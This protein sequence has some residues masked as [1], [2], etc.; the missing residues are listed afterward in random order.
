M[1]TTNADGR[2]RKSLAEQIDRLDAILDG[3]S[4]ALEG[5]VATAVSQAVGVAVKEAVQGVLAEV[6]TNPA[7]QEKLRGMA[8]PPPPAADPQPVAT[9]GSRLK[10]RLA[11]LGRRARSLGG[12]AG[13]CLAVLW[14]RVRAARP[15]GVAA[16]ALG[17]GVLAGVVAHFAG[18]SL[19]PAAA[20]ITGL[21]GRLAT[22]AQLLVRQPP[23]L[24]ASGSWA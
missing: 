9:P 11:G 7:L 22:K 1:T 5:A 18:W 16:L 23:V 24:P 13:S 17:A 12:R 14:Q 15:L 20:W 6:L 19:A 3:L 8:G 2:A 10:E 4:Q 21:I